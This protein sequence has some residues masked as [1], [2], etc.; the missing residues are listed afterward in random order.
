MNVEWNSNIYDAFKDRWP[1]KNVLKLPE[2]QSNVMNLTV[3]ASSWRARGRSMHSFHVA[4]GNQ[5]LICFGNR[6]PVPVYPDKHFAPRVLS[7]LSW[8]TEHFVNHLSLCW[9]GVQVQDDASL[10]RNR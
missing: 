3:W 9:D 7:I 8:T 2:N 10:R 6:L 5:C 1:E 4:A